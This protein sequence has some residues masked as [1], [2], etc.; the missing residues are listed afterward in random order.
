MLYLIRHVT[1]KLF[2]PKYLL[3]TNTVTSGVLM[4]LGDAIQQERERRAGLLKAASTH[5]GVVPYQ[6]GVVHMGTRP[7]W[8]WARTGKAASTH[9]G[10]VPYQNGVVHMGTRPEWDWARTGRMLTIGLLLGPLNHYWYLLLDRVLP[11]ATGRIVAK[12]VL[13][14]EIIA[15]PIFTTSFFMGVGLLE[16]NTVGDSFAILR[17][18]FLTVYMMD[19]MVW[20]PVQAI[21]FF[22]VPPQLRVLYVNFFILIWDVFLSFMANK[23]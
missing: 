16:G 5:A 9:A 3:A 22:F 21:N 19:L 12:K 17:K 20:P 10:V 13:L 4:A 15:S 2:S 1:K 7:E 23:H 18:K 11:G 6:N 8:D 14:D